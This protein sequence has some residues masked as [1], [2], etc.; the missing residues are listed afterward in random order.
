MLVLNFLKDGN[1][2]MSD[3]VIHVDFGMRKVFHTDYIV[4]AALE[5]FPEAK[6]NVDSY[7]LKIYVNYLM[8]QGLV[9]DDLHD[10]V[11]AILSFENYK[12]ADLVIKNVADQYLFS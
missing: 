11:E 10:A 12:S 4:D 8:A 5:K 6:P 9:E 2:K 7:E 3:N 1:T